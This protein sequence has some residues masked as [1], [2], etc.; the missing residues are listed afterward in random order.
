MSRIDATNSILTAFEDGYEELFLTIRPH[1]TALQA[2]AICLGAFKFLIQKYL[3][4]GETVMPTP[5]CL[6]H[7]ARAFAQIQV[8]RVHNNPKQTNHEGSS[9]SN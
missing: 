8:E 3:R 5:D 7:T 1:V 4:N 2:D 6:L 9:L